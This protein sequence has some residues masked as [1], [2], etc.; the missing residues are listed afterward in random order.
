MKL[1]AQENQ[2]ERQTLSMFYPSYSINLPSFDMKDRYGLTHT[3]GGGY[4]LMSKSRWLL[5]VEG[6]YLFGKNVK[7]SG[8]LFSAI[9][10]SEGYIINQ[11]GTYSNIALSERGF[12]FWLKGGKLIPLGR[13]NQNSGLVLL[14]GIGMIQHKI[15]I[16]ISQNDAP[17]LRGD[18][19]KGYDHMCNGPA[20]TEY[21]GYQYLHKAKRINFFAGL[22][23]TFAMT[24]SR[25]AFYFTEM[26]RP[27]ENRFDML[28]G[29]K[30]GWVIP[31]YG[32]TGHDYYY[33]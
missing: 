14:T 31:I 7:N 32:K 30:I 2:D 28:S 9:A 24:Q 13:P 3:V 19:K 20:L 33:Y 10:T 21:I 29:I 23:F 8:N 11:S 22:E 6:N 25:R 18:Y 27:D 16:D 15:R 12:T 4:T 17:P 1:I 26:K 5:N